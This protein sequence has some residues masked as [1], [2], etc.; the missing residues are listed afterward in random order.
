[1][2]VQERPEIAVAQSALAF[3]GGWDTRDDTFGPVSSKALW[4][5]GEM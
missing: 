5:G 4:R 3:R 2:A 1:M